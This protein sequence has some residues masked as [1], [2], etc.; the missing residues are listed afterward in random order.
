MIIILYALFCSYAYL[1]FVMLFYIQ[2]APFWPTQPFGAVSQCMEPTSISL[3]LRSKI[4][5]LS[6]LLAFN[7]FCCC[8]S[9][10][11]Y[12][13]CFLPSE[14]YFWLATH[15][16]MIFAV[17]EAF[18]LGGIQ[19]NYRCFFTVNHWASE[20]PAVIWHVENSYVSLDFLQVGSVYFSEI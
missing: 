15:I 1:L 10:H 14:I 5:L 9:I 16:L 4:N 18:G 11:F 2:L 12:S 8:F 19:Q 3:T 13:Q 17:P 6:S 20:A 7:F